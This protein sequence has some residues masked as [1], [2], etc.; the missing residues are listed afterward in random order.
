MMILKPSLNLMLT[1]LHTAQ[2]FTDCKF[3]N[4]LPLYFL[5]LSVMWLLW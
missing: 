3:Q 5:E 4:S 2:L 1:S